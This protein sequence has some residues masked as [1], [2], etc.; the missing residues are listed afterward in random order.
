MN[1][2]LFLLIQASLWG[3]QLLIGLYSARGVKSEDDYFLMGR[4]LTLFPLACTLLA[5]QLGGGTLLGACQEA[6]KAGWCVLFYPLG[7][8]L[9]LLTVGLGFGGKLRRMQISTIPEIFEHVYQAPRLRLLAS[10][11]SLISL[12]CILIG[13]GIA[14]RKFFVTIGV[15]SPLWFALFWTLFVSYTVLGGFKAVVDTDIIQVLFILLTLFASLIWIDM[16]GISWSKAWEPAYFS[17]EKVD[18]AKWFFMPFCFMLIEQDMGQRYFATKSE[19]SIVPASVL[20]ALLLM[21]GSSIAVMWG[22]L[23]RVHGIAVDEAQ[24]TVLA[25]VVESLTNPTVATFFMAAIVMAVMSTTDSLLCSISAH[26]A[27]DL[28][29]QQGVS[30]RRRL[31]TARLLTF[32]TGISALLLVYVFSSVVDML[33]F[34]YELAVSLL[35][36]PVL[37]AMLLSQ[38]SSKGAMGSVIAG[39]AGFVLFRVVSPFGMPKEVLTLAC[40]FL[41]YVAGNRLQ[42][43]VSHH[44]TS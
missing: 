8:S 40:S 32:L 5:T 43:E 26:L 22:V 23:A 11:I 37:M 42:S 15:T 3:M 39:A 38:P 18:W 13:M 35:F 27:C 33:M 44:T 14:T 9:G 41:G 16:Q 7:A 24:N 1:L 2:S 19:S 21:A 29:P 20:S 30:P 4:R 28:I 10:T 34:A 6:Y 17:M 31:W 36:V 12:Y 25:T